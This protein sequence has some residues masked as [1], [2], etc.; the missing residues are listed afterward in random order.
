[1]PAILNGA[2]GRVFLQGFAFEHHEKSQFWGRLLEDRSAQLFTTMDTPPR[3]F[4]LT[5]R[6]LGHNQMKQTILELCGIKPV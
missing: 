4:R 5:Y 6:M 1:M 2:L 3:Y